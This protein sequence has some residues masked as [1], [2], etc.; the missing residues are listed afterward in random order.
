M[1]LRL[2]GWKI[3][4]R[5]PELDKFVVIAY[6]HTSNWDF[7]FT[8]ALFFEFNLQ[9]Y[10]M[11]KSTLFR[12]PMGPLMRWL[13]GIPIKL[14]R[15]EGVVDQMTEAFTSTE[16]LVVVISPEANRQR[17]DRWRTGFY[18]IALASNIPV[19]LGFLDFAKKEVGY[20]GHLDPGGDFDADLTIIKAKYTGVRGL[21]PDQSE[22]IN[23]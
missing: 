13:G 2:L 12:G 7:P 23:P 4:G 15:S 14:D 5:P 11:G 20:L 3:K 1:G 17:V 22:L 6:P 21:Y 9:I 8:L 10:W 18:H 19:V 16:R